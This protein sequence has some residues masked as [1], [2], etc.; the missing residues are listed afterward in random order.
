MTKNK[1]PHNHHAIVSDAEGVSG[2]APGGRVDAP[3]PRD[4]A[5]ADIRGGVPGLFKITFPPHPRQL[6]R[7]W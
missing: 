6:L 3:P 5:A 1:I 7:S 2:G 4:T